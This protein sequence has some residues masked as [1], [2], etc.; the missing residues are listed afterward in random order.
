MLSRIL[1]PLDGSP[2]MPA[3]LPAIRQLVSG[4]GAHVHLLL[5]RPIP[6]TPERR[7]D[8]WAY[9]DELVREEYAA[10]QAYL[11][12]HGSALAYDGIV[13]QR[14]VRFGEPVSEIL[15]A[16][17]RQGAHLIAMAAPAWSWGLRMLRPSLAQQLTRRADVPV[18]IIPP[19]HPPTQDLRL[20]YRWDAA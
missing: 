12:H 9:L 15:A 20:W 19:R 4:T 11:R 5:V 7:G 10:G 17:S 2:E 13:L 16:A 18:L 8:G 3:A 14:E 6:R 1:I